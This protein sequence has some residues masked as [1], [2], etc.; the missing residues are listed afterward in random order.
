MIR[1]YHEL[2]FEE[3][4]RLLQNQLHCAFCRCQCCSV[5]SSSSQI[6]RTIGG[7]KISSAF[8]CVNTHNNDTKRKR[9]VTNCCQSACQHPFCAKH[10]PE[11]LRRSNTNISTNSTNSNSNFSTNSNCRFLDHLS[12]EVID[13][14]EVMDM[15]FEIYKRKLKLICPHCGLVGNSFSLF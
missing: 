14:N 8:V 10:I 7:A 13:V 4:Q 1:K 9:R 3:H 12:P 11:L 6:V 2:A 15:N 5:V